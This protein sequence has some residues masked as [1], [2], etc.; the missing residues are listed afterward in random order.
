MI[1]GSADPLGMEMKHEHSANILKFI[2]GKTQLVFFFTSGKI[3]HDKVK[4]DMAVSIVFINQ[5]S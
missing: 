3:W 2:M 4:A 5:D 1:S